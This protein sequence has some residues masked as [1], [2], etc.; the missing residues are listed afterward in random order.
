M[1]TDK[2]NAKEESSISFEISVAEKESTRE[3]SETK[4]DVIV[5]TDLAGTHQDSK[6]GFTIEIEKVVKIEGG[7]AV[8][9]RAWKD[10]KQVGFGA[11]GSV[12]LERFCFFNP[13]V[14][15]EAEGGEIVRL[16]KD[17][18]RRVLKFDPKE[19]LLRT[20]AH[21]IKVVAKENSKVIPGLRGNT[22]STFQ[23][24]AG[25]GGDSVDGRCQ[26][27][28]GNPGQSWGAKVA[29]PGDVCLIDEPGGVNQGSCVGTVAGN[30]TNLWRSI[31]R[32]MFT[33]PT[34]SLPDTDT[35]SQAVFSVYAFTPSG[36]ITGSVNV[37]DANPAS[38]TTLD[39][40]GGDF[41]AVGSTAFS[42]TPIT[43]ANWGNA[44]YED[45]TL[46][47]SGLA[48]IS[49]TGNSAF[50]LRMVEDA[51]NSAPTWLTSNGLEFNHYYAD[52]TGTSEDPKLVITH[53][54]A[55]TFVPK[56]M[57]A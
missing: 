51:T 35:I 11:K 32:S 45:F 55:V 5:T 36:G 8:F 49:K 19:A 43:S 37:Y 39:G 52:R 57:F 22:V 30:S 46:N 10:G 29:E 42:D 31:I 28:E 9:A 47:A 15:C 4:A 48:N 27:G 23:P 3:K 7:V 6:Y 33:F 54:A 34:A 13:P 12:D 50:A 41:D 56:I 14:L 40:G 21:T 24:A 18:F 16:G 53:E 44:A 1:D 26:D 17:G 25:S 2:T 20:L 38:M